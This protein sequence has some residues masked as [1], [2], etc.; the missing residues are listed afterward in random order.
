MT[1]LRSVLVC[2]AVLS[3]AV[4]A[5]A[6]AAAAGAMVTLGPDMTKPPPSGGFHLGAVG[7]Q[8]APYSPC[9]YVNM[10]S[11]NPEVKVAAPFDGVIVKWRTRA[12][13]CT[14][15]QTEV[16][17]MTLVTVKQGAQDGQ[18]GFVFAV[19][20]LQGTAFEL[21]PGSQI[22]SYPATE[23]PARLPIKQNERFGVRADHPF[24]FGVDDTITGIVSSSITNGTVYNGEGYGTA[25]GV[26]MMMSAD[27]EPDVDGDGY[28]DESQDCKPDDPAVHQGEGCVAAPVVSQPPQDM[29][30]V[31]INCDGSCPSGPGSGVLPGSSP[32]LA[33][34]APP[35]PVAPIVSAVPASNDGTRFNVTLTCPATATVRCGGVLV[36][37]P[38][39]GTKARRLTAA[40][41]NYGSATY[42]IDPG[43]KL[44]VK[45]KLN[46]T[47]RKALK[48]KGKLKVTIVV[49]PNGGTATS[50]T[51]TLTAKKTP[52]KRGG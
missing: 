32:P 41:K 16:K 23:F 18:F 43:Q 26:P 51:R 17:T 15:P 9:L 50:V 11:T 21:T 47:G 13:C 30:S 38:A 28:G 36:I 52:S 22:V 31:G 19:P 1:T 12:G 25:I 7:C 3:G 46:A 49:Q 14:D 2:V 5:L 20:Q 8:S 27:V 4:V 29:L 44:A 24:A 45:V 6:L 34:P 40:T 39:G 48:R 33:P 42:A 10:R 35:P 37:N